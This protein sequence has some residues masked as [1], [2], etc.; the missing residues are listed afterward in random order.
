MPFPLALAGQTTTDVVGVPGTL[1]APLGVVISSPAT[2]VRGGKA[3]LPVAKVGDFITIHG[4]PRNPKAPGFNPLCGQSQIAISATPTV[5][6][7]GVPIATVTSICTCGH[8]V[9]FNGDPTI[10]VGP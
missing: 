2:T 10:L 4:N 6:V 1:V 9:L 7:E 5:Y 3:G 8:R